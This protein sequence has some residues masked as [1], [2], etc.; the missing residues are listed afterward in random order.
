VTGWTKTEV[1]E[2]LNGL[3][4][5][6][7][8]TGRPL[9]R[10]RFVGWRRYIRTVTLSDVAHAGVLARVAEFDRRGRAALLSSTGLGPSKAPAV[11][12]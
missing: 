2:K 3:H 10:I 7:A 1:R 11:L 4:Q 6:E 9:G 5:A 8:T 12:R